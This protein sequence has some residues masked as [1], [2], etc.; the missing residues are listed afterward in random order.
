MQLLSDIATEP[1]RPQATLLHG[2]IGGGEPR[3]GEFGGLAQHLG[4]PDELAALLVQ[5]LASH[6]EF[7]TGAGTCADAARASSRR[8]VPYSSGT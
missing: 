8:C 7:E 4:A 2:G 1:R 3:G 5:L 6:L